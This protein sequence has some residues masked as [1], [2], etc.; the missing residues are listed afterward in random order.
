MSFIKFEYYFNPK[1]VM[2][3]KFR[4]VV[5]YK[6]EHVNTNYERIRTTDRRIRTIYKTDL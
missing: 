3:V 5:K 4:K 2:Y 6:V 1:R